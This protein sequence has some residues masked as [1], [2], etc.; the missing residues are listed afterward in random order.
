MS[1]ID[2]LW[3]GEALPL[4]RALATITLGPASLVY[5]AI[6]A[7]RNA[8]FDAGLLHTHRIS[9]AQVI[10]VGNLV[11]G[12]SGKTPLVIFLSK[13]GLAAGRKVA[14][15]TRGYG[16]AG[17]APLQFDG[18]SLPPEPECGDEPR[19]IA[20]SSGATVFVDAD[21]V[22]AA[23]RAVAAGFDT[24]ILDDGFQHRRLARDVDVLIRVPEASTAVLPLGPAREF[25][26]G[27]RRATVV[28]NGQ[29]GG[30]PTGALVVRGLRNGPSSLRNQRVVAVAGI[31][32]PKRFFDTLEGLGAELVV[33]ERF[34]DHHRF[35][36]AELER[37]R[38]H[39]ERTQS[40]VVTTEKDAERLPEGFGAT[41]VQTALAV[42]QGL[43][44]LAR[45]VG[46]PS[47]CA[48]VPSVGEAAP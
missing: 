12:G 11:V 37:I 7:T 6:G 39:A 30:D 27:A 20:R 26:S 41:V 38:A 9:G 25:S 4:E 3:Y 43:E 18:S 29:G 36:K 17:R 34:P 5:G 44:T 14:V 28:W 24:L 23:R 1:A 19:L 22:A 45:A 46:W 2:R 47:A 33:T 32:R 35:T 13:W 48:P 10:S 15:L 16:R 31:A 42:T 40:I 21:R 8:L